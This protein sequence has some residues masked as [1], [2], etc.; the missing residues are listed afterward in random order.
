MR[1]S[2]G[3]RRKGPG[4]EVL[5]VVGKVDGGLGELVPRRGVAECFGDLA[6]QAVGE[7]EL[8]G[9]GGGEDDAAWTQEPGGPAYQ[10][11]VVGGGAPGPDALLLA[12]RGEAGGV[13][14]DDVV[15]EALALGVGEELESPHLGKVVLRW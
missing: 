8:V 2:S 11:G 15:R 9:V 3:S 1:W 6:L 10:A 7:A 13:Q 4:G 14:D 12:P 5:A